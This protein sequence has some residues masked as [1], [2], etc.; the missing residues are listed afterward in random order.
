MS[1]PSGPVTVPMSEP[2]PKPMPS[3]KKTGSKKPL[4]MTIQPRR[5]MNRL[6]S[7]MWTEW[8]LPKGRTRATDPLTAAMSDHQPPAEGAEAEQR[9]DRGEA[10]EHEH[11]DRQHH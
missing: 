8:R 7:R 11:M 1:V 2:R 3:R 9:A 5:K 4:K 10:H 6:R